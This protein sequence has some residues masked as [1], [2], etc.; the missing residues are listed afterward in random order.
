MVNDEHLAEVIAFPG[1]RRAE[2]AA[3]DARDAPATRD[4]PANRDAASP[5][6]SDTIAELQE[7]IRA[8]ERQ[9]PQAPAHPPAEAP[10]PR[11]RVAFEPSGPTPATPDTSAP[12]PRATVTALPGTGGDADELA[13][14]SD[15]I[16]RWLGRAP[17]SVRDARHYLRDTFETLGER[18]IEHII[19][20][21]L[22]LGY[23]DDALFA[24]QLR[25]GRFARK[26]LG[27]RAM[28]MEYRKLGIPD[29]IAA[30]ALAAHAPDDDYE[31]ALELARDRVRRSRGL[32]RD[33]AYRR[34]HAYLARR[35]FGGETAN[36]ALRDALDE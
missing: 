11:S 22:E 6:S 20:R 4:A 36:R 15:A 18:D 10:A 29:D 14:A 27:R 2:P 21:M 5:G 7:R 26:G 35:G 23:L 34:I 19:D 13:E 25:D 24:E 17:R 8:V 30:E 31:L 33:T 12:E 28:E 1:W 3:G 9:A 32:D 16:V